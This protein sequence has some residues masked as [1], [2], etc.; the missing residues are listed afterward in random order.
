[1]V[2]SKY[3]FSCTHTQTPHPTSALQLNALLKNECNSNVGHFPRIHSNYTALGFIDKFQVSFQCHSVCPFFS[4]FP[5][6]TFLLQL[7]CPFIS[8]TI[9]IYNA[10]TMQRDAPRRPFHYC[11]IQQPLST[12]PYFYI[13]SSLLFFL[14]LDS[15][16]SDSHNYTTRKSKRV[17][18]SEYRITLLLFLVCQISPFTLR[19]TL[20]NRKCK[21]NFSLI[22]QDLSCVMQNDILHSPSS[23]ICV[24]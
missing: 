20:E 3:S 19:N 21:G 1:M 22:F 18:K 7:P 5:S 2:L 9:N 6:L 11:Y 24:Y 12:Y 10:S 15:F 8:S 14:S 16:L 23:C 13:P 17:F 4:C